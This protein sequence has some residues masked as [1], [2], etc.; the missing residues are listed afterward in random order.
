MVPLVV[1]DVAPFEDWAAAARGTLAFLYDTVGLDV[2]MVTRLDSDEQVVLYAHPREVVAVGT[3]VPWDRSFCRKMVT[4][5]GPRVSTVAAATPAYANLLTGLDVRVAAYVGVPLVTRDGELYGTLCGV[6][7]R[8]QPRSLA[9]SLA[10]V[11]MSA[12]MLSTLLAT[13]LPGTDAGAAP[14]GG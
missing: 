10:V 1:D 7:S 12:R 8:A 2:W 11:E 6:S 14:G 3:A 13:D 9:R 4:G 5:A